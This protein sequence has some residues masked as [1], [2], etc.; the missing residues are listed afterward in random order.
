MSN[1]ENIIESALEIR[2]YIEEVAAAEA[3]VRWMS[4]RTS[5]HCFWSAGRPKQRR[6]DIC[7]Q[8]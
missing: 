3:V 5:F 8:I 4:L 6:V 1:Q 2:V 7:F